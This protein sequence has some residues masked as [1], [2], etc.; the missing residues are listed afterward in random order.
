MADRPF[1]PYPSGSAY[2]VLLESGVKGSIDTVK[3]PEELEEMYEKGSNA[4]PHGNPDKK[5]YIGDMGKTDAVDMLFDR[6]GEVDPELRARYV[7]EFVPANGYSLPLDERGKP[8]GLIPY[9]DVDEEEL[10]AEF[11]KWLDGQDLEEKNGNAEV[12][13]VGPDSDGNYT[14]DFS[15]LSNVSGGRWW[16][17]KKTAEV[18]TPSMLSRQPASRTDR[19]PF[20][21]EGNPI[22][23]HYLELR[24]VW[25][26]PNAGVG[27][28]IA[29]RPEDDRIV[30]VSDKIA[31]PPRPLKAMSEDFTQKYSYQLGRRK[32]Q[33][34]RPTQLS[35]N[36]DD[37]NY[38]LRKAGIN[39]QIARPKSADDREAVMDVLKHLKIGT[40]VFR[41]Q[42]F[43]V[44]HRQRPKQEKKEKKRSKRRLWG[45]A[46]LIIWVK[47]ISRLFR[48][49]NIN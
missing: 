15:K 36:V 29:S 11:S 1:H 20:V 25:D 21:D 40:E 5:K 4:W 45:R 28:I 18:R 13:G 44:E 17:N 43:A 24:R 39:L 33:A 35:V 12:D 26:D 16:A 34:K 23:D 6:P 9:E 2:D 48:K 3:E 22:S 46:S 47:L 8:V 41:G 31:E 14:L 37:F 32:E 38:V 10:K 19:Q 30:F 27:Y 7:N 49:L 42:S